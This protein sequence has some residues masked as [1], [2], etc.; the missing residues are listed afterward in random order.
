MNSYIHSDALNDYTNN[1]SK[2]TSYIQSE[3]DFDFDNIYGSLSDDFDVFSDIDQSLFTNR[4]NKQYVLISDCL[5]YLR[6]ELWRLSRQNKLTQVLPKLH[7]TIDDQTG[8]VQLSWV[9]S[10]FSATLSFEGESESYDSYCAIV[11]NVENDS[12]STY[13]KRIT[14]DNY[15]VVIDELLQL[16]LFN[17]ER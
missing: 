12:I 6:S 7:S 15:K 2:Q 11:F 9:Y 5:I 17:T 4:A 1:I 14:T 13:S 3:D 8:T 16:V 10:T